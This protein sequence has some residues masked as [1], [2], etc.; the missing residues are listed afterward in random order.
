MMII[1]RRRICL[2]FF[3]GAVMYGLTYLM[4]MGSTAVNKPLNFKKEIRP[5]FSTSLTTNS[6]H[7][8]SNKQ[9]NFLETEAEFMARY[10]ALHVE[11][12]KHIKQMCQLHRNKITKMT[13]KPILLVNEKHKMVYCQTPKVATDSW[14]RI[15]LVLAGKT[16]YND[17]MKMTHTQVSAAW[18][19]QV[20]YLSSFP[21]KK[22]NEILK[23]Y[24]TFMFVRNP[25]SRLL[26]AYNDKFNPEQ[27][28]HGQFQGIYDTIWSRFRSNKQDESKTVQFEDFLNFV[29]DGMITRFNGHWREMHRVCYPCDIHY[30]VIG[31]FEDIE[32]ESKY[33][34]TR[35]KANITFPHSTGKHFTNSSGKLEKAYANIPA[36]LIFD[37][38]HKFKYDFM[39]FNYKIPIA[40]P[41]S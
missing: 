31:H 19:K 30:D 2:L 20:K 8:G 21:V 26:S 16:K 13:A 38:Y 7:N 5:T 35:S 34:L 3:I 32:N 1:K 40:F 28:N 18:K 4:Y 41:L 37:I 27:K 39:L 29:I 10:S 23:N 6:S 15:M 12:N 33:I 22:Q 14:A 24:T 25:F 17:V 11:R 9:I 36:S